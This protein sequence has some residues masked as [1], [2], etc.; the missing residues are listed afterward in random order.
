MLVCF[1]F[2]AQVVANVHITYLGASENIDQIGKNTFIKMK[3]T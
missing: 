1:P 3:S 2:H